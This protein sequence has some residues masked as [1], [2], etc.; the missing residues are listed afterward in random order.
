MKQ[1]KLLFYALWV[2]MLGMVCCAYWNH[3]NN[4]FHF[5]DNHTIVTNEAVRHI[6]SIP[7]FFKDATT[8]SSLPANQAWRPGITTIDAIDCW[9]GGKGELLRRGDGIPQDSI[10]FGEFLS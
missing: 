2:L 6:D 3:F 5:D 4:P 1:S 7:H 8:F 9:I 10:R